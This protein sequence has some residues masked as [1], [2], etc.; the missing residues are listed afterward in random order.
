MKKIMIMLAMIMTIMLGSMDIYAIEE[1]FEK[2]AQ[3]A[4]LALYINEKTCEI[5]LEDIQTKGVYYS[6][7]VDRKED[8]LAAGTFVTE[9]ASQVV[10]TLFETKTGNEILK[11][12]AVGSV[13]KKTFEVM[14]IE[15][16]V[17][18]YYIFEKEGIALAIQYILEEDHMKV[19]IP[20]DKIK[21]NEQYKVKN[22][23]VLPYF[24]AG[25][26][27]DE[28]YIFV[29]DGSGA[30][31]DFNTQKAYY[32]PYKA[33][34]YGWDAMYNKN[35]QNISQTVYMPVFGINREDNGYLAVMSKGETSG[36]INAST[37]GVNTTYNNGY[38]SIELRQSDTVNVGLTTL[39]K[40]DNRPVKIKEFEM[41]YYPLEKGA[42]DYIGMANKYK[43]ILGIEDVK[44]TER[45][46]ALYITLY[47]AIS[48]REY[49]F[50]FPVYTTKKLTTYKQAIEIL[51]D[52]K[53]QGIER[54]VVNYKCATKQGLQGKVSDNFKPISELGGKEDFKAL[55][56]YCEEN[57][58]ELFVEPDFMMFSNEG[59][60]T[61]NTKSAKNLGSITINKYQTNLVTG[62]KIPYSK[63]WR[64]ISPI[65]VFDKVVDYVDSLSK[66]GLEGIGVGKLGNMLYSDYSDKYVLK[67]ESK[68][69]WLQSIEYMQEQ[70]K[71]MLG[72]SANI[73]AY[74]YIQHNINVPLKS[75]EFDMLDESIPFYQ[76]LMHGYIEYGTTPMNLS[77][78]PENLFLNSMETGSM[79]HY[80]WI[81]NDLS[82]LDNTEYEFLY[83]A[84]YQDWIMD[85]AKRYKEVNA[86]YQQTNQSKIIEHKEISREIKQIVYENG[87]EV[88]VNYGQE[89]VKIEGQV[90]PARDYVIKQM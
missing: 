33:P 80:E 87:V 21:E 4:Q 51:N 20:T 10:V 89:D 84:Q 53:E 37:G 17:E 81:Y 28:G 55:Q 59:L 18:V 66:Y 60:I 65:Y 7:P 14:P 22:I 8:T 72:D 39:R 70:G 57:N 5:A 9:L 54:I 76:I 23:D 42:S 44:L 34:I 26:K 73:Y 64:L 79:L 85:A 41:N 67:E 24:G 62:K 1:G 50:G 38:F 58:V 77:E 88:Y 43:D 46:A 90:V 27:Q 47:G 63:Q 82:T 16:G 45:E 13:N 56:K 78:N 69:Y 74:P 25:G 30:L 71:T 36:Y 86:L 35:S 19:I 75:S 11:N 15:N 40:V 31:I 68:Q 83:S 52:L 48:K 3:N 6:N 29:P 32:A 12:S 61:K 2:V 49:K